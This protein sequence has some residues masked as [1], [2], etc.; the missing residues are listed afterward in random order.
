MSDDLAPQRRGNTALVSASIVGVV[1]VAFIALL[2]T[3][4]SG[5][6]EGRSALIGGPA[7]AVAGTT[8]DGA[9][10]DLDELRGRWVLVN[11]FAT[12]C[13][14]CIVEHPE[15]VSFHEA[16]AGSGDVEVVSVAFQD[17]GEE[18]EAFFEEQGGEWPVL[19]EGVSSVAVSWGV[20]ALPESFLVT[21]D[22]VVVHKFTGGVTYE[23]LQSILS[24]VRGLPDEGGVPDGDGLSEGDGS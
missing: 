1:L 17:S 9:T 22:G 6:R 14:P 3:R 12:W 15:L 7:P 5:D 10:F 13:P 16:H 2:A 24:Q 20:S 8:L 19:A 4:D 21:P 11:F 18:I 23:G